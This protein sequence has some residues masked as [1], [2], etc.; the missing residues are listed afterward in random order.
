VVS[1]DAKA[2]V[3][4]RAGAADTLKS[5]GDWVAAIREMTE[6]NGADV[7]VDPVGG[8]RFDQSLRA[9]APQGRLVVVGFTEG[10]IPSVQVNRILFRNVDVVGA[11]WGAFLSVEPELFSVTQDALDQMVARGVVAPI[12]GATFP[13]ERAADA[14]R[15][16]ENREATGKIVV[17]V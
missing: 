8:D 9:L 10:R 11:A 4:R 15:M 7:I 17:T 2:A 5:T 3:A 6:G 16:L 12:V 13:L 1:T 14:L